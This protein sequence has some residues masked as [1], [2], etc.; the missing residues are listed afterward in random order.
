MTQS[1][2]AHLNVV[3]RS[4]PGMTG[5][6][7]ED[8]YAVT[9]LRLRSSRTPVLLAVLCDGIGG[10]RAGEVAAELAVQTIGQRVAAG[11]ASDPLSTLNQAIQ[12]AS[13]EIYEHAQNDPARAGM[14]AT[15]AVALV[16]G[17]QL[18]TATVG[19]SRVYLLR[20]GGIRQLSTDH[21]W[22]QEAVD[23]GF[24]QPEQARN[25]PNAHVIRRYLGSPTPPKVDLRLR[26][27]SKESDSQ[28]EANQ[29]LQLRPGDRLLLC[30]DGL[31]DLVENAEI[32]AAFQSYAPE[33]AVESLIALANQRGGHDNITLVTLG[34]PAAR[35][36]IGIPFAR[37]A[38]S[39][40]CLGAVIGALLLAAVA[41]AGLWYFE[42]WPPLPGSS[43][44]ATPTLTSTITL[45]PTLTAR[46]SSTPRPTLGP[47][48]FGTNPPAVT[49]TSAGAIPAGGPTLTPWPTNTLPPTPTR[50]IRL[51]P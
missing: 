51:T 42:G 25:H 30:S 41:V 39:A 50:F 15:T 46:P 6:N 28:S 29:G 37:R 24:L 16:M 12:A 17:N 4:H 44:S 13:Q 31:T 38:W 2:Q 7:N 43:P 40:G 19:D 1:E 45:A 27:N 32:L 22:V 26:M 47:E 9:A 3:A 21:T 34:M 49:P 14:G 33:Q 5:K 23:H 18:Y 36:A 8:R 11:A 48:I 10:H 35:R 20:G